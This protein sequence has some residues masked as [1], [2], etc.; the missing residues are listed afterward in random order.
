MYVM[1]T[2]MFYTVFF[3]FLHLIAINAI[4]IQGAYFPFF[5]IFSPFAYFSLS[6]QLESFFSC[7]LYASYLVHDPHFQGVVSLFIQHYFSI[8][9]IMDFQTRASMSMRQWKK[10]WVVWM[11]EEKNGSVWIS[12][13]KNNELLI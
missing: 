3:S 10:M 13:H 5:F 12:D 6:F 11:N 2:V 9:N 4:F 7:K 8:I 1:Y